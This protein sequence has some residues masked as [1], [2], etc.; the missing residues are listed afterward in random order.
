MSTAPGFEG[1]PIR[2]GHA[3]GAREARRRT[4]G[5]PLHLRI[6]GITVAV[7]ARDPDV[8]V[9]VDDASEK[10]LVAPSGP[11]AAITAGWG[12]PGAGDPGNPVFDS[13]GVWKLYPGGA[14][15]RFV[16]SSQA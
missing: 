14:R 1:N 9:R 16:F 4:H 8:V 2:R 15:H 7:T 11:D 5:S 6:A 10:F 12:D 3:K 13:G